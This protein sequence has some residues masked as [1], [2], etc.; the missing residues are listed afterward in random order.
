MSKT[1]KTKPFWV[2]LMHGDLASEE[3]HDHRDGVCDMPP[4]EEAVRWVP[5]QRCYR[6]FV[7]TGTQT[8]CCPMCRESGWWDIPPRKRQRIESK[9]MCRNWEREYDE[10]IEDS[11]F[12]V[13]ADDDWYDWEERDSYGVALSGRVP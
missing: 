11:T 4:V 12:W 8:C 7:Y 1:D 6:T 9:R 10:S 5:G 3:V 13:G 2:K